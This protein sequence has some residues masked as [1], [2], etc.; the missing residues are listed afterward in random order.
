VRHN[1]TVRAV[2]RKAV[3][4]R[5]VENIGRLRTSVAASAHVLE[6]AAVA[7]ARVVLVNETVCTA[8]L[9][10][11]RLEQALDRAVPVYEFRGGD[12][13]LGLEGLAR[14]RRLLL[15]LLKLR[16]LL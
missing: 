6:L 14:R 9:A 11:A 13:V 12:L 2:G 10:E 3:G 7:L 5:A 15:L 8:D 1:D 4:G 16:V